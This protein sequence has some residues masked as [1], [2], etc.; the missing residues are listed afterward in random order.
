M[1]E[2]IQNEKNATNTNSLQRAASWRTTPTDPMFRL[3]TTVKRGS[4][5]N[6]P[7]LWARYDTLE[8]A[9]SAA[10]T[11]LREERV[12]HVMIVRDGLGHEFVEWCSR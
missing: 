6:F 1:A 9:R 5:S 10:A 11:L 12:G 4:S 8:D 7:A 3:I 2:T